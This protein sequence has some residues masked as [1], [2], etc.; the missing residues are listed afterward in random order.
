ME[1]TDLLFLLFPDLILP[2]AAVVHIKRVRAYPFILI[3]C[4]IPGTVHR[5]L[6]V[7]YGPSYFPGYWHISFTAGISSSQG[8]LNSIVYG[9]TPQVLGIWREWI[10]QQFLCT[11]LS[12]PFLDDMDMDGS[13][14]IGASSEES[15]VTVGQGILSRTW[16]YLRRMFTHG[17]SSATLHQESRV[18]PLGAVPPQQ[19]GPDR[20]EQQPYFIMRFVSFYSLHFF[21]C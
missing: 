21:L 13:I 10:S 20:Q 6:R 17:P 16:C 9:T 19:L 11:C 14:Y 18:L 3:F 4:N 15:D 5:L 2:P 12:P 7:V 1:N 8:L